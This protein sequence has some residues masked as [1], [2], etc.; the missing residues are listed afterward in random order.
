MKHVDT[1]VLVND[2][3]QSKEFY[4]AIMGLEIL[5]DWGNMI[6]F[7]ERFAIHSANTLLP[8]NEIRQIVHPGKQGQNNVIIYFEAEDLDKAYQ[9]MIDNGVRI[10]H[11]IV[12][13]P[14]QRIFRVYLW[15][16]L[17]LKADHP[18]AKRM[19]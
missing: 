17:Q 7:K 1:I 9:R 15:D 16:L 10:L 14:W 5:H 11:G 6:V 4:S 13:L 3:Y 2:I 18:I 19:K 8:E 12:E